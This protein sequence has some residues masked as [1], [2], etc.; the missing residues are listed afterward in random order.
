MSNFNWDIP[1]LTVGQRPRQIHFQGGTFAI[2]GREIL[3]PLPPSENQRLE[4]RFRSRGFKNT[5]QYNSW[6]HYANRALRAGRY[7]M[8]E[9]DVVVCMNTIFPDLRRRDAQN[10]EKAMFDAL[11]QS[12]CVYKDDSNVKF[13]TN[14]TL[15]IKG[16][17]LI[18]AYVFPLNQF[19]TTISFREMALDGDYI[20]S[21]I[22]NGGVRA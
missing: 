4:P 19:T 8:I 5:S 16:M 9:G 15:I 22:S 7:E 21:V 6:L 2:E 20:S 3:L 10:Y 11:T 17:A 1:G 12:E 14:N 18:M 13:H